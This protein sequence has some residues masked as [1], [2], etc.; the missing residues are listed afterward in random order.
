[1]S[2]NRYQIL[3]RNIH[4][5]NNEHQINNDRQY[6]IKMVKKKVK[7]NSEM[8]WF[9]LRLIFLS[10]TFSIRRPVPSWINYACLI[11]KR[12]YE[13]AF[14]IF[15]T[16]GHWLIAEFTEYVGAVIIKFKER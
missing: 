11:Q 7:K 8:L 2:R 1:M 12:H 4:F 15:N 5:T 14:Y 16:M 9:R 10:S 6:K 13:I 3:L